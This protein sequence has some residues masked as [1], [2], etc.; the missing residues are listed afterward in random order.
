MGEGKGAD[1]E[2]QTFIDLSR[3]TYMELERAAGNKYRMEKWRSIATSPEA[4]ILMMNVHIIVAVMLL[5][6]SYLA[7]TFCQLFK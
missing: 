6:F 4:E 5:C 7:I 3:Q 1:Q 2:K